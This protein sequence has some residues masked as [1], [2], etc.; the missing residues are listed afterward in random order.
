MKNNRK[1][2]FRRFG[3]VLPQQ[4]I[5]LALV[6]GAGHRLG[7]AIAIELADHGYAIALHYCH[8]KLAAESTA[9]EIE[10]KNVPV[11]LLQADLENP[12]EISQLFEKISA[13][14][15]PLKVLVN[16]A[17]TMKP[18]ENLEISTEEWDDTLNLNLRAPWL[19]ARHAA[20]LMKDKGGVIINVTDASVN[21]TGTVFPAYTVSKVGLEVLTRIL[22]RTLAPNIRVNAVAPGLILP[23]PWSS[24]EKWESLAKR[25]PLQHAG[26]AQD[27]ARAVLFLIE[28]EYIT[29][30]TLAVD[31]GYRLI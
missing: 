27:V 20:L 31:G 13:F 11:L 17:A 26:T 5:P 30:Q 25:L 24:L 16:S 21:R 23:S 18:E 7:R 15:Y 9:Y 8:S 19:C 12:E 4:N 3:M 10:N 2:G 22:A 6:T 14:S 28:N 29:G 1:T